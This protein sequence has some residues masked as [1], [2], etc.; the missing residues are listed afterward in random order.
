MMIIVLMIM[1]M[2]II[3]VVIMM[4]C[5]SKQGCGF[6]LSGASWTCLGATPHP[7]SGE[8]NAEDEDDDDGEDDH[9]DDLCRIYDTRLSR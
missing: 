4:T 2:I 6:P 8:D 3:V 1:I 5:G 7:T 9:D